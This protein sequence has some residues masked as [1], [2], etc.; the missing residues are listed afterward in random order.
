MR[1]STFYKYCLVIDEW[2]VNG[3]NGTRA[4]MKFYPDSEKASAESSFREMVAISRIREY[5]EL[6]QKVTSNELNITLT[7]QLKVL[8]DIIATAEK[9][10]DKINAIKEQNKLLALYKEHNSQQLP[11]Q[12][13]SLTIKIIGKND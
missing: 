5:K 12:L 13:T 2:L 7:S 1:D 11:T 6:K 4:Y 10:S 3:F 8:S 9:E